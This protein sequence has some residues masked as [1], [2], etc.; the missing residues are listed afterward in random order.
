[1]YKSPTYG[2]LTLEQVFIKI[3]EHIMKD[4]DSEYHVMIG[5]DS[6]QHSNC[7]MMVSA[8]ILH[9]IHRGC[10]FFTEKNVIHRSHISL[11]EKMYNETSKSIEIATKFKDVILSDADI[12]V[13]MVIHLD[14][15]KMGKTSVLIKELVGYVESCGF[16]ACIKDTERLWDQTYEYPIA[17]SSVAD[18]YSK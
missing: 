2:L 13:D 3:K 18:R 8:I 5:C 4:T 17:A 12:P 16:E 9:K 1:M 15:G 6:Q 7:V 14:I 11:R 10:I